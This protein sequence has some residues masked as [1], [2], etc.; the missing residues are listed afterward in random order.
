MLGGGLLPLSR[1]RPSSGINGGDRM[2]GLGKDKERGK[3]VKANG[4]GLR[5]RGR[6]R[7]ENV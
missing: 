2:A 3:M 6:G 1:H 7:G 4:Y 5:E